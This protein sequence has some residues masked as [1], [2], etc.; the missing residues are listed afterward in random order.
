MLLGPPLRNRVPQSSWA[1]FLLRLCRYAPCFNCQGR[2]GESHRP[3]FLWLPVSVPMWVPP[4]V[5]MITLAGTV[6]YS[7][8][9]CGFCLQF[10]F[11][12]GGYHQLMKSWGAEVDVRSLHKSLKHP[13]FGFSYLRH[14]KIRPANTPF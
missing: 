6:S 10:L 9:M 8:V 14:K 11:S 2:R 5:P 3:A 12:P 13:R 4:T 1:R 7:P